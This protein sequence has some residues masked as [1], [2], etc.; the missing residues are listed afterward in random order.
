MG[1]EAGVS[2]YAR[3][4]NGSLPSYLHPFPDGFP[5]KLAMV[6]DDQG[7]PSI[8]T[9]SVPGELQAYRTGDRQCGA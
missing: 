1:Q 6:R 4:T 2:G 5:Y 3:T 8:D 7:Q 9:G